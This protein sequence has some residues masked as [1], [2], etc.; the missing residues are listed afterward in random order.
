[1]TKSPEL[2][3]REQAVVTPPIKW[4]GGKAKEYPF[5]APFMPR[6]RRYI[7]PF[8]GGGAIYF[9]LQPKNAIINDFSGDLMDFYRFLK[10]DYATG[11]FADELYE[12]VHNWEKIPKYV[13]LFN[14]E[15]VTVYEEVAQGRMAA[16]GLRTRVEALVRGQENNFNG[17]FSERFCIDRANLERQ[18]VSNL[19]SKLA[20]TAAIEKKRH[21][22][23]PA[24]LDKNIET[25]FRS[26][27]YMHFR[28]VMNRKVGKGEISAAKY[29]ATYYFIREFCYGAM[30]RYN[31][32]GHFNIPY[33]GIA[34]NTKDFRKKVDY[35]LSPGFRAVFAGTAIENG[36]FADV[37]GKYE[38]SGDDFIFL[39]PPYD[40]D[41]SA[42]DN[43]GF[44]ETDHRR[45]AELIYR[46]PAKC[47]LLIKETPFIRSLYEGV[48]GITIES[49]DKK[50]AYNVKGRN[51]R[52]VNH[53][54]ICNYDLY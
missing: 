11:E 15:L 39:D 32:S 25:A 40:S 20:R 4:P 48:P 52:D 43:N 14:N 1:M 30:F 31:A 8:F 16:A 54:I 23:S 33:G 38:L 49:F 24:D 3:D 51:D 45:L 2:V 27:F 46:T 34:Y 9:T 28:D 5:I 50:Y 22:I 41:F 29:T 21:P 44:G 6:F 35:I 53:L 26:G 17:L 12:Y 42:Y 7:E 47:M 19:A 10:G 36:D 18:I 13:A 37:L